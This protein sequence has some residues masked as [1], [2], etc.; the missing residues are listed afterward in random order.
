MIKFERFN[1]N[2]SIKKYRPIKRDT[3]VYISFANVEIIT[4][5][6]NICRNNKF[7]ILL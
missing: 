1:S 5:Y 6:K 7:E 2:Y 3:N 4:T